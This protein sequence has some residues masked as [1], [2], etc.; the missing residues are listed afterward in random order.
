MKNMK[1]YAKLL[2]SFLIVAVLAVTVGG[3]GIYGMMRIDDY[4]SY[5]HENIAEP[6]P[7]L[8]LA[9]RTLL[10]IRIH[11]RDMVLASATGDFA[12]VEAEFGIIGSLLPVLDRYMNEYR[13]LIKNPEAIRLFDE[14]RTLYE[15]DL[16]P[17]VLSIHAASQTTDI[18]TILS[19]MERCKFYSDKILNNFRQC[20][21]VMMSGAQSASLYATNLARTLFVAIIITLVI[22]VSITIV[23]AL[24]ISHMISRPIN[25]LASTLESVAGGDLTKRLPEMSKDEIGKASHSFN[26]TMEGLSKMINT[27]KSQSGKLS[28]VGNDLASNMNETAAAVNEIT[29]NIQSIK[30]RVI[31]Q[32]ASVSET[33]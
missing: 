21:E 18:P 14:A 5:L 25:L 23:L 22:A 2:F 33:N 11:V 10:T 12:R 13:A 19:A 31:N 1:L 26:M 32:S 15:R 24:Y 9:E 30:S 16:V 3:V 4:G 17:V 8:A 7:R 6:M 27:I 20:L 29:A 28:D